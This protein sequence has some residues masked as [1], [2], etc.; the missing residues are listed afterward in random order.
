M[1]KHH[2]QRID[3][4]RTGAGGGTP[5]VPP[6]PALTTPKAGALIFLYT[7]TAK[8]DAFDLGLLREAGFIPIR[9]ASFDDV[10]VLD[11][12]VAGERSIVMKAAMEAI[13][14]ADSQ[15]GAKTLFGK[16]LSGKFL[17]EPQTVE[18]K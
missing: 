1:K 6:P 3:E 7:E 14:K 15:N 8:I 11:P 5:P 13:F 12:L 17:D 2:E 9:V 4:L 18:V 16:F 10:K